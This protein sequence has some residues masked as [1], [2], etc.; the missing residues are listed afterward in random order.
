MRHYIIQHP[1]RREDQAPIERQITVRRTAAP[2]AALV[3]H[4]DLAEGASQKTRLVL[5]CGCDRRTRLAAQP[6][7]Q[8]PG[9]MFGAAGDDDAIHIPP[10]SAPRTGIVHD[11][12]WHV[13]QRQAF[14]IA[15]RHVRRQGSEPFAEPTCAAADEFEALGFCG[16]RRQHEFG[17]LFR[18]IDPECNI[19]RPGAAPDGKVDE[20]ARGPGGRAL[21]CANYPDNRPIAGDITK[22]PVDEM[23]LAIQA[24]GSIIVRFVMMQPNELELVTGQSGKAAVDAAD[25]FIV[26]AACR[27][28]LPNGT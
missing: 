17:R 18:R 25:D 1:V 16:A 23:R 24:V 12:V 20:Y 10:D 9:E 28:V 19:L 22:V 15:E 11:P 6:V 26:R 5:D 8:P 2:T 7:L 27:I 13:A 21:V 14:T 3:A 4:R